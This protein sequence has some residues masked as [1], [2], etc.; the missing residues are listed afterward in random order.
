MEPTPGIELIVVDEVGK[1]ECF[2]PRFVAAMERLWVAPLPLLVTVAAKGG[3]FISRLKSKE[4]ARLITV[5]PKN[6]ESLPETILE[7]LR[8]SPK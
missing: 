3:G 6:R 5:T 4:G 2:S 1:M 8:V 7:N